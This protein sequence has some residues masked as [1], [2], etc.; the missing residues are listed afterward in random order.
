M[1]W[2]RAEPEEA[3][4]QAVESR[5]GQVLEGGDSALPKSSAILRSAAR[6]LCVAG[7]AKRARPMLTYYF[8]NAVGAEPE[9]LVDSAIAGELIHSASLMHDDVI[10]NATTRRGLP[11]VNANWN[12]CIAVLGGNHLL[13]IAFSLLKDSTNEVIGDAVDVIA[14]MTRAAVAEFEIRGQLDVS[15]GHWREIAV[16][17][18]GAL[19][20]WCGQVA[21]RKV[22]NE[23][24]LKRFHRVGHHIGA[25]FQLADDVRDLGETHA[26]KDRFSD[27]KNREPS[28]PI[29]LA[30][31]SPSLRIE[32]EQLWARE[33]PEPSE[34]ARV[35]NLILET[36]VAEKTCL[37]IRAEIDAALDA[38]GN[39]SRTPGGQKVALWLEALY[40]RAQAGFN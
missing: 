11:S 17:K 25:A 39:F 20:A 7:D 1:S 5:L 19:F 35:G 24:A 12:N 6:H 28:Y 27:L 26:L 18:T 32:V 22:G 10:D 3:F 14:Q 15:L 30:I 2:T 40:Q 29:L 34:I 8:G 4:L 36:Q 21:A 16:G 31:A 38:L 23:E 9:Q 13:S 37:A 33:A